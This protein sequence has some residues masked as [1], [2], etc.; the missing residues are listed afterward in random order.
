MGERRG[1]T[2]R[3]SYQY[4]DVL[5][6]TVEL[7]DVESGERLL[8]LRSR[9]NSRSDAPM[10]DADCTKLP[11]RLIFT[12]DSYRKDSRGYHRVDSVM[13]PVG[14]YNTITVEDASQLIITHTPALDIAGKKTTVWKAA[15]MLAAEL[16]VSRMFL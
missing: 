4:V 11:V 13:V 14:L 8:T 6:G 5:T 9:N 16:D 3:Q 15:T 10:R 2:A 12:G 7:F 1:R